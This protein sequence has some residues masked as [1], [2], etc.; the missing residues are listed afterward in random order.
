VTDD[1]FDAYS[2]LQVAPQA[3]EFVLEAAYRALARHF[4]PDGT[5]PDNARMAEINRAYDLVRTGERRK[6]YDRLHRVRPMGPGL[7]GESPSMAAQAFGGR[8]PPPSTGPGGNGAAGGGTSMTVDFGRYAGWRL[9][10]LVKHDP[11][12][13]RWLSR[14]SSGVRYRNQIVDLLRQE[15]AVAAR[16][17]Y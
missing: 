4:H 16:G 3:E 5:T 17:K 13:M 15:E 1:D 12:Y 6:R 9:K 14:H 7:A 10:D 8:V 2:V 11:D